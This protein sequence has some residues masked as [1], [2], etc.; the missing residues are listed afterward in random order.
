M[1]RSV[2]AMAALTASS[3][4]FAEAPP[5]AN[6]LTPEQTAVVLKAAAEYR[7]PPFSL[8]NPEPDPA[9]ADCM[10]PFF[11]VP[12]RPSL[13][14]TDDGHGKKLY[15][16]YAKDLHAY[17]AGAGLYNDWSRS[18]P[19]PNDKAPPKESPARQRREQAVGQVIVK[20]SWTDQLVTQGDPPRAPPEGSDASLITRGSFDGA[21]HQIGEQSA[22]FIMAKVAESGDPKTDNGWIYA[23]VTPDR[24]TITSGGLLPKCMGC[25]E[26]AEHD[27]IFGPKQRR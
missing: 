22:L 2:L 8:V 11:V 17:R 18:F 13:A 10:A 15:Y 14:K 1:R 24:K 12:P 5:A 9:P 16:L 19:S 25:H 7:K 21:M 3:F 4:A 20:E 27:R 23:T 6:A 26:K